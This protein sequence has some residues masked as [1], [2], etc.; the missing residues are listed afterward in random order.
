[1]KRK[2]LIISIICLFLL[3]VIDW[4]QSENDILLQQI[5]KKEAEIVKLEAEAQKFRDSLAKTQTQKKTLSNQLQIIQG[6][7]NQLQ[8]ELKVTKAKVSKTELN[9][10]SFVSQINKKRQE[11]DSRQRDISQSLRALAYLDNE[12][13]VLTLL[14]NDK[15]SDFLSQAQY[16][17]NLQNSLYSDFK[18]LTEAKKNLEGFKSAEEQKKAELSDLRKSLTV[19]NQLIQNQKQDKSQLLA[20][21]KNQEIIYQKQISGIQKK[22]A[23]IQQE[24]SFLEDKLRGQVSGIPPSRPGALAW[25]LIGRITQGYGPTSITGF[26]N[27]AYK[28]HNGI[29]LAAYYGAPIRAALDGVVTAS[30]DNNR[31]AYGEWLAIRHNNGLTTLYAHLSAKAAGVGQAVSQGQIIGYEGSTGFVTGPHLHFTVYSTNTFRVEKRWFGL[32]PLGGSVNPFD[33]LL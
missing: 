4:A 3:P 2:I 13:I 30:G 23:E 11:I 18:L 25:P 12:N 33:Y 6:Q 19:Q 27:D 20:Q 8:S 9:I 26:Y 21:T 5:K 17:S 24:I 1:M 14:N 32:L 15:F 16:M 31:Y 28:F 22:Q 10:K 7:I 29:D